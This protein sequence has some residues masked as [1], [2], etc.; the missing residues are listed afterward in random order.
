MLRHGVF[1]AQDDELHAG[2]RHRHVH[3]AEVFQ[4]SDLSLVV[5]TYQRDEDHV[6]LL[7][8]ESVHRV[9]ADQ[10]ETVCPFSQQWL[11]GIGSTKI[12]LVK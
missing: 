11:T 12:L 2:T 7:S 3:A 1:V 5:G 4:E 8:L 9:D 10:P 6:A